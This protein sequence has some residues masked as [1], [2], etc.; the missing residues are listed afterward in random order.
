M[1]CVGT[2][3]VNIHELGREAKVYC[4]GWAPVTNN[5]RHEVLT[6]QEIIPFW[7]SGWDVRREGSV[8][9]FLLPDATVI[10]DFV[11]HIEMDCSTEG[12]AQIRSRMA[13]YKECPDPVIW[14][15][16]TRVRLAGLMEN[17][18]GHCW[19]SLAGTGV[20]VDLEGVEK[21]VDQVCREGL[22]GKQC[23]FST[24]R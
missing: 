7:K 2:I 16:Q 5:L 10:D 9:S 14:F 6:T 24:P 1:R 15:A 20:Y 12:M 11:I 4:N 3:S 21:G 17:A 18:K 22:Y 19:F 8:D 23:S 13:K